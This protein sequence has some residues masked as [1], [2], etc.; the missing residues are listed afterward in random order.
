[1]A[2]RTNSEPSAVRLQ[3]RNMERLNKKIGTLSLAHP[4]S[5]IRKQGYRSHTSQGFGSSAVLQ[6]QEPSRIRHFQ[7]KPAHIKAMEDCKKPEM[8]R[9][10]LPTARPTVSAITVSEA[11]EITNR[12]QRSCSELRQQLSMLAARTDFNLLDRIVAHRGEDALES[13]RH[14]FDELHGLASSFTQLIARE[15]N[16][17]AFPGRTCS[18]GSKS[19]CIQIKSVVVSLRAILDKLSQQPSDVDTASRILRLV[20][21]GLV[22]QVL[23]WAG[24]CESFYD[25]LVPER[26]STVTTKSSQPPLRSRRQFIVQ[27]RRDAATGGGPVR[28]ERQAS[29]P[30]T[31]SISTT[32]AHSHRFHHPSPP[33][34]TCPATS[35]PFTYA[36]APRAC[37]TMA[38]RRERL[39]RHRPP[40]I[41]IPSA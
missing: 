6:T 1:M 34:D 14:A 16:A 11:A 13:L 28:T 9:P 33:M 4:Q 23:S 25:V 41:I 29:P 20:E 31:G 22:E 27:P 21:Q 32:G 36:S 2:S 38:E 35:A 5:P 37:K 30:I 39:Q 26:R 15:G 19:N 18:D 7:R 3:Q 24:E 8:L 40:M 12:A 17:P 10:T